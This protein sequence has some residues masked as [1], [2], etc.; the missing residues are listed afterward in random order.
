MKT[1]RQIL[2]SAG[3]KIDD[4]SM[5][6]LRGLIGSSGVHA[7][8]DLDATDRRNIADR[9]AP[10]HF[11]PNGTRGLFI[12]R[13]RPGKSGHRFYATSHVRGEF[14]GFRRRNMCHDFDAG[15]IFASGKTVRECA[16]N[17]V[18][19]YSS[20]EYNRAGRGAQP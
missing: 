17:F 1:T 19:A 12:G 8:R 13:C 10:D 7:F 11:S 3:F 5:A 14:R 15:N 18:E 6:M 9:L 2:A 16:A 4:E 20:L